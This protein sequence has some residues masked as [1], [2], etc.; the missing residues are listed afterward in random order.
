MAHV[1]AFFSGTGPPQPPSRGKPVRF[2]T[3][4]NG[5]PMERTV[6]GAFFRRSKSCSLERIAACLL[7]VETGGLRP[8]AGGEEVLV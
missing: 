2:R 3:V 4:P 7:D 8:A 5:G 1:S 6:V